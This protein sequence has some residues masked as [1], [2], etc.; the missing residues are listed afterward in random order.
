MNVENRIG[1]FK[2]DKSWKTII[3]D[4]GYAPRQE[5][6]GWKFVQF[7]NDKNIQSG[8][9]LAHDVM[10]CIND[11]VAVPE[12]LSRMDI[13]RSNWKARERGESQNL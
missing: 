8:E 13:I 12:I 1:D 3:Q 7:R 9:I 4:K 2:F 10:K 11:A 6:G 5:E